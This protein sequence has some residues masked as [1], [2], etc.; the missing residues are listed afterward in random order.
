MVTF[1]RRVLTEQDHYGGYAASRT[2]TVAPVEREEAYRTFSFDEHIAPVAT[3]EVR[4]EAPV[5]TRREEALAPTQV[6]STEQPVIEYSRRPYV[7]SPQEVAPAPTRQEKKAQQ[8]REVMF[9]IH[10][11]AP[12]EVEEPRA[13]VSNRM[14][15]Y[16]GIYLTV[17]AV[18][19]VL[20]IATGLAVSNI[21]ADA[22]RLQSAITAQNE[23]LAAQNAEIL[24]L[25]DI[26]RITGSAVNKG[27]QKVE[28]AT[29]V[30]LLPVTDP[31]VYQGRT[32][33]FDRFCDW[34]SK[35]IGG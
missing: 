4:T 7:A 22:D 19:A 20:V 17:A 28:N 2:T 12:A 25:T 13:K 1:R 5:Q 23:V 24:R 6:R 33:W 8:R 18:L 31:M 11:P 32:N 34:L 21:S 9:N 10:Q 29:Q 35:L 15:V 3:E 26:D 30:D 14:K 16:L 27:M